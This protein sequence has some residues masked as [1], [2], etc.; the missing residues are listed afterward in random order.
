M[1]TKPNP[2]YEH[3]ISMSAWS[4]KQCFLPLHE[5]DPN[6]PEIDAENWNIPSKPESKTRQKIHA[7]KKAGDITPTGNLRNSFRPMDFLKW[8]TDPQN[9]L[10]IP[11]ELSP[12]YEKRLEA[13]PSTNA[14][15]PHGN[16]EHH[17][18]KREQVL[19]A[20]LAVIKKYP[21]QAGF[22]TGTLSGAKIVTLIEQHEVELWSED[23]EIPLERETME[24]QFN[25]WLKRLNPSPE[26]PQVK[27]AHPKNRN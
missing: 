25:N 27:S 17:A 20:A 3:W 9:G 18:A 15:E 8:A 1:S 19:G 2:D 23:E 12:L 13:L 22:S 4:I 5:R 21:E 14:T 10:T 6:D 26:N 11:T 24:K 7:A 16:I